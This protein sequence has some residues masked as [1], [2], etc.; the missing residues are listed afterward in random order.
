MGK[1]RNARDTIDD[2]A[3]EGR[4]T[5]NPSTEKQHVLRSGDIAAVPPQTANPDSTEA[6]PAEPKNGQ[7]GQEAVSSAPGLEG[8]EGGNAEESGE[9]EPEVKKV[10]LSG[11]QKK[12]LAKARQ[13]EQ[14]EAKKAAKEEAKK[15]AAENGGGRVKQKGQNKVS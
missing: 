1:E 3:A 11:A 14:W 8:K 2:D 4:S 7:A 5:S 9:G 10:R 6:T 13:Q 12:A 15:E